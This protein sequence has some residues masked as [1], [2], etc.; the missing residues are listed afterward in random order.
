MAKYD[1]FPLCSSDVCVVVSIG[2][3]RIDAREGGSS[4]FELVSISG[5]TRVML[6]AALM[7]YKES[8]HGGRPFIM[9]ERVLL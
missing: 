1:E 4:E 8:V 3:F 2:F 5:S 6:G 7:R 9:S